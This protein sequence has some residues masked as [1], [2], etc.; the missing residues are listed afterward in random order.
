MTL[1]LPV[2][3]ISQYCRLIIHLERSTISRA[4]MPSLVVGDIHTRIKHFQYP[5]FGLFGRQYQPPIL[6]YLYIQYGY[7][8][9]QMIYLLT[10]IE[11]FGM[12]CDVGDFLNVLQSANFRHLNVNTSILGQ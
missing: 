10:K 7:P 6:I 9:S 3:R 12:S 8:H 1:F 2:N 5:R 11:S 4:V